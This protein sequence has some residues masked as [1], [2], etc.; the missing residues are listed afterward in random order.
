MANRLARVAIVLAAVMSSAIVAQVASGSTE[1]DDNQVPLGDHAESGSLHLFSDD[2]L[3]DERV[4]PPSML[5]IA[6]TFVPG[7]PFCS[8]PTDPGCAGRS[9]WFVAHLPV[10]TTTTE[11]DCIDSVSA[12][13][14]TGNTEGTFDRYYPD[15]GPHSYT[16]DP[17]LA[18]P[19]GRAPSVWKIPGAPHVG[20]DMYMVVARLRGSTARR[21]AATFQIVLTPVSFKADADPRPEYEM[22][23]WA[24][25]G[26]ITGPAYDRGRFRCAYWGESGSCM[27]GRSFPADTRFTVKVRLHTEPAGWLHGRINE[28]S[29]T[30][31]KNGSTTEVTVSAAPVQVPAFQVAQQHSAYSE[32]LRTAFGPNGP[33]G[34]GGS[35]Q[36]GGQDLTDLTRRNAE[37]GFKSYADEA[38]AQ[39]ALVKDL[40]DDKAD[41]A[42]WIW[43]VR[44]L[45]DVEMNKAGKC[46]TD[47]S[48][49]KGIVT[50]NAMI[51][52]SGPPAFNAETKSIDYKVA[53]PHYTRTGD[54]FRGAYHLHMRSDVARCF[55]GFTDAPVTGL[56][57]VVEED[58]DTGTAVTNVRETDGWLK[59]AATGFTHSAPTV[60]VALSQRVATAK[61]R[62]NRAVSGAALARAARLTVPRGA[63]VSVS[64]ST[65]H[66]KVC[67][68]V[69]TSVQ[70]LKKGKCTATVTVSSKGKKSK[71]TVTITVT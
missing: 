57:S 15:T 55:Y 56:V 6:Q 46:L 4:D 5:T 10:C 2:S 65:R 33:Y 22:A 26:R 29:I 8:G 66:R 36:P 40:I 32:N 71:R 17:S 12:A 42:P 64:V 48:G 20:G 60:K 44:T 58:G 52:G 37:Y 35:R 68:V 51:Y 3:E 59:V 41:Y 61:V 31:T 23:K 24:E 34:R 18:L 27:L 30:F 49:V 50:T 38:F 19:T 21:A 69:K 9:M 28:P 7:Q 39:L 62:R 53:A 11:V 13:T 67:R 43:R 1:F 70:G 47:G 25:P 45:E 16:G 54:V 63:K 14:A